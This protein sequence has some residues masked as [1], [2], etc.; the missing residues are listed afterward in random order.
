MQH[1]KPFSIALLL[2]LALLAAALPEARAWAQAGQRCF[3]ETGQCIA[4]RI[5]TWKFPAAKQAEAGF[6][7]SYPFV[8]KLSGQ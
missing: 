3:P 8:F 1:S 2:A 6:V 4:G 5:R 7:I